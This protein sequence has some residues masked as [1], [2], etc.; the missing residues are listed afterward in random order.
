MKAIAATL[1]VV[2]SKLAQRAKG[3]PKKRGPYTLAAD[4]ELLPQIRSVRN[5]MMLAVEARFNAQAAP[6]PIEF[7]TDNGSA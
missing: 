7:L 1:G 2:R 5:V 3:M 4:A 6:I